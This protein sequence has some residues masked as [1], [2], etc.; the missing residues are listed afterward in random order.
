[1]YGTCNL[2]FSYTCIYIL[3]KEG[4]IKLVEGH[5]QTSGK[6]EIVEDYNWRPICGDEWTEQEAEVACR[7]LGFKGGVTRVVN[8]LCYH[9]L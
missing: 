5:N 8:G 3:A 2:F 1:M 6:V 7:Q 4:T 9:T